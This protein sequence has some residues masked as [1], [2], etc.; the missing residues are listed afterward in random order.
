MA[1][2]SINRSNLFYALEVYDTIRRPIGNDVVERSLKMG[3]LYE[4]HPDYLAPNIN[5]A[6]LRPGD[7]G[8]LKRLVDQMSEIW[9]FHWKEMPEQ[10]W[11]RA[12]EILIKYT[13]CP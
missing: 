1:H 4:L 10:D 9:T 11:E 8:E 3:F 6:R 5:V 12:K 2:P 13:A 7:R